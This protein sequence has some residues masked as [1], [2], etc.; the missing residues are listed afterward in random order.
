[1][2]M[3]LTLFFSSLCLSVYML[4]WFLTFGHDSFL[5]HSYLVFDSTQYE[6]PILTYLFIYIL[7]PWSRVL[8]QKLTGFAVKNS[9]HFMG[10]NAH[11]RIHKCLQTVPILSQLDPV[12]TP[13]S[14]FL[15]IHLN[16]I[17]PSTPGSPK[18]SLSLRFHP[19]K[20]CIQT[21]LFHHTRYM[22][23]PSHTSR[24]Y[25]PNNIGWGVQII[26][27]LIMYFSPRPLWVTHLC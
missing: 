11:Y 19:P 7:T 13:T 3:W 5:L 21:L 27:L 6:L 12:R 22:L 26:K 4:W 9:P 10:P 14:I 16:I 20:L 23:R 17:L 18:R 1:M 2:S 24:F 8:L 15:K 25:H